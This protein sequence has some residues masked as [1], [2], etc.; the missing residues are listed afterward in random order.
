MREYHKRVNGCW[1][2]APFDSFAVKMKGKGGYPD[3]LVY[4]RCVN[5]AS[6]FNLGPLVDEV[7]LQGIAQMFPSMGGKSLIERMTAVFFRLSFNMPCLR[8]K[9]IPYPETR[10]YRPTD[11]IP[12]NE[13]CDGAS[14]VTNPCR[15]SVRTGNGLLDRQAIKSTY[16]RALVLLYAPGNAV[17]TGNTNESF[18]RMMAHMFCFMLSETAG[19]PAIMHGFTTNNNVLNCQMEHGVNIDVLAQH[20]DIAGRIKKPHRFPMAMIT[21]APEQIRLRDPTDPDNGRD[22]DPD[23]PFE[24]RPIPPGPGTTALVSEHGCVNITGADCMGQGIDYLKDVY[25]GLWKFQTGATASKMLHITAPSAVPMQ[26]LMPAG[27]GPIP[28]SLTAPQLLPP[29]HHQS[30]TNAPLSIASGASDTPP[31]LGQATANPDGAGQLLAIVDQ[32]RAGNAGRSGAR[33]DDLLSVVM[34]S[35]LLGLSSSSSHQNSR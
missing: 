16:R 21:P 14:P 27:S 22:A 5:I 20:S 13:R 12:R 2:V 30:I 34:Q 25:D 7:N 3:Q 23:Q 10:P 32:L 26:R 15:G 18:G 19:I 31:P 4:G 17:I 11:T 35:T 1:N 28:L 29:T 6:T 9:M 33:W 24:Y 8:R